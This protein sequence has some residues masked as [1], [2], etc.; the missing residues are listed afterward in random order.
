MNRYI[1]MTEFPGMDP[2]ARPVCPH[3]KHEAYEWRFMSPDGHWIITHRC[4]HCQK[5]VVPMLSVIC[6]APLVTRPSF[7]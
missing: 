1:P 7:R 5:D 4:N 3:C 2:R 6:N